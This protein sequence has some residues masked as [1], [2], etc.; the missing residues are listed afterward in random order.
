MTRLPFFDILRGVALVA[1]TVYHFT[2]DLEF[3]GWILPGT[4]LETG[5]AV[6]ARCIAASFLFLM[7]LSLVLAHEEKIRWPGF[8][9]RL[10][11]IAA[12]AA[13][14]TVATYLAFPQSFI[15]FGI[16]HAIA[17]FSLIGLIFIRLHWAIALIAAAVVLTVWANSTVEF[18]KAPVFW[19]IGLLPEPPVSNDY[20]P[21]F[22]WLAATLVGIAIGKVIVRFGW[23]NRIGRLDAPRPVSKPLA[24][25]GR[26][27]LIYYLVHQPVMLGLLWVFTAIAGPPDRTASFIHLCTKQCQPTRG[28][29]FCRP[30]CGCVADGMKREAIFEPFHEGKIDI[31]TNQT[32]QTIIEQCTAAQDG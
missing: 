26:H 16:L 12:A 2:W 6:F 20:V 4:T 25:I 28:E 27:S 23:L 5:W 7:G 30:Y 10:L 21:V 32:A 14:I 19:W 24:F 15:F 17:A 3:Y 9:K 8:W 11:Q 31:A 29:K 1:M 13:L 22:P 18:F